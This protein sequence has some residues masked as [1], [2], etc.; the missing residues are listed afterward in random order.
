ML[1]FGIVFMLCACVAAC[2][3]DDP[4]TVTD[5]MIHNLPDS[6]IAFDSMVNI[7]M[8]IHLA[9]AWVQENREDSIAKDE[10]LKQYYAE[11]FGIYHISSDTYKKSYD[12]YVQNPV[13]MQELFAKVTEKLTIMES[14]QT[15]TKKNI[16]NE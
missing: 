15:T 3:P 9:E 4:N 5:S 8:D 10:R 7:T 2:K 16:P 1:R 13:L 11:I 6:V 14:K 12:Y